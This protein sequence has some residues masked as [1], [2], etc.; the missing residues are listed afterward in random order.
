MMKGLR[1]ILVPKKK[2][3]KVASHIGSENQYCINCQP[4]KRAMLHITCPNIHATPAAQSRAETSCSHTV[5]FRLLT[6]EKN[7][8]NF[9][10]LSFGWF[11]TQRYVSEIPSGLAEGSFLM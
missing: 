1:P 3:K 11:V 8:G 4:C 10:Q 2:A 6:V 5:F 7:S 9:K